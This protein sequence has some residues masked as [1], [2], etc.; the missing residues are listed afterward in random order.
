MALMDKRK[1]SDMHKLK[2]YKI[3]LPTKLFLIFLWVATIGGIVLFAQSVPVPEQGSRSF[4]VTIAGMLV[5]AFFLTIVALVPG[6]LYRRFTLT[7]IVVTASIW[8]SSIALFVLFMEATYERL[9]L[10]PICQSHAVGELPFHT[11]DLHLPSNEHFLWSTTGYLGIECISK[12]GVTPLTSLTSNSFELFL[13][14]FGAL[15]AIGGAIL[16][17]GFCTY[18]LI[19]LCWFRSVPGLK[20]H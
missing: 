9:V 6:N 10:L 16:L 15:F 8:V 1:T 17:W 13:N 19:R 18:L 14:S 4:S 5:G 12:S 20:R 11:A 2:P 3:P 7:L